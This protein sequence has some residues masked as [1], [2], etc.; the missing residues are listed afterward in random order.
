MC[1]C[2]LER[3]CNCSGGSLY[4]LSPHGWVLPG[5]SHPRRQQQLVVL[6]QKME[7]NFRDSKSLSNFK[8]RYVRQVREWQIATN[9]PLINL[10]WAVQT[11]LQFLLNTSSVCFIDENSMYLIF[12]P[13]SH[14][15]LMPPGISAVFKLFFCS[16]KT[17]FCSCWCFLSAPSST[18]CINFSYELRKAMLSKCIG[19]HRHFMCDEPSVGSWKELNL[20]IS[21]RLFTSCS[22][23]SKPAMVRDLIL[24]APQTSQGEVDVVLER[25]V[26]C[27]CEP[28]CLV[29]AA[30]AGLGCWVQQ[31]HVSLWSCGTAG[32]LQWAAAGVLSTLCSSTSHL[33]AGQIKWH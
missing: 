2:A 8:A 18:D 21:L 4:Q 13:R 32:L 27:S 10:S 3:L 9:Q 19:F 11:N 17:W 22:V 15:K 20:E 30:L 16:F 28:F 6:C 14:C 1:L 25:A 12:M 33:E 5:L 29:A 23:V 7:N 24:N 26:L 31:G